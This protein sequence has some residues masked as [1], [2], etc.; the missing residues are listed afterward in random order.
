MYS[1]SFIRM[2]TYV[3][4]PKK[5]NLCKKKTMIFADHLLQA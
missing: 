5:V 4:L 2:M 1:S 3:N